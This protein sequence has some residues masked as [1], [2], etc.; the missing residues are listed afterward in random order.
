MDGKLADRQII[1]FKQEYIEFVHI[2]S[3]PFT[4]VD[5]KEKIN[6]KYNLKEF[7][8]TESTN[9]KHIRIAKSELFSEFSSLLS[10]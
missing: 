3:N 8:K 4:S 10:A 1:S 2:Y 9:N 7:L 6:H 5:V